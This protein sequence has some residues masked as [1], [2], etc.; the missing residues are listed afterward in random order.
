MDVG[1]LLIK[2]IVLGMVVTLVLGFILINILSRSTDTAV[3]RL[4]RETEEVR[5]KQNELN[6]KIKQA[7]EELVKR[8]SEADAL[9]AKMKDDAEE[10]A[11][12]E[13]EKIIA[14][15]RSDSEEIIT[16]AQKTKDEIRKNIEKEMN[17]KAIDFTVM[18]LDEI[19]SAHSKGA[20][21]E[22]LISDFLKG[23]AEVDMDMIDEDVTTA[24][25]VTVAPL[26]EQFRTR[27]LGIIK[28]KLGREI[29]LNES[30]D[31]KIIGGMVLRFG[32][33]SLD[34]SMRNMVSEKGV[35]IK[36]K[37]ERGLIS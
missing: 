30:V 8:R 10:K 2:A 32:S 37:L 1:M 11:K 28:E 22:T 17:L 29:A 27:L 7:N 26:A 21:N 9:V 33:L 31:E 6:T 20:L 19:F 23:L 14:K 13:R 24:D 34:G 5:E 3:N 12:A 16:K 18:I 15:A 35:Q 36:E 4:N 25:I